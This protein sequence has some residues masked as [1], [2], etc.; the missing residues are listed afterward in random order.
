VIKARLRG[1]SPVWQSRLR[2]FGRLRWVEKARIVRGYGVSLREQPLL[3]IRYVLFDPEVGDFSY[4]LD[5]ERELVDFLVR[6]LGVERATIAG[7]LAELATDERLRGELAERVRWRFDMKRQVD[8]GIRVGWYTITRAMKPRLVVETGIKHGLGS[9][10]L[11]TALEHNAREG[12]PGRLI[13]FD[14]DPF[15]GWMV[16]ERLRR[17]WQ[18]IFAS[19]FDALDATL[20]GREVDLIICDTPP[21]YAIESFE[22]RTAMRHASRDI[23][24]IAGN[25]DRTTALPELAAE[26]NGE[27][28]HFVERPRCH[29]YPGAGLGL[30]CKMKP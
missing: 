22:M 4:A 29:I 18:P 5:N 15:S 2:R 11:L 10:V 9:L 17:N 13:S 25:G 1:L 28:N 26:M 19:T 3:V 6:A 12:S 8:F 27:Y 24:L 21:D 14:T 7:Y 23:A 30:A 20:E 16:P